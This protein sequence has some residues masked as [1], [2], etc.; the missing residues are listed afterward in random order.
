VSLL[1]K[2]GIDSPQ[3]LATLGVAGEQVASGVRPF[4]AVVLSLLSD[5]PSF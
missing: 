2:E 1:T 5:G 3:P 4:F